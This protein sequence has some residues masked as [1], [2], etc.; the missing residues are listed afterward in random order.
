M[1][2]RPARPRLRHDPD[3]RC[4]RPA[5]AGDLQ[6]RTG[7][8][9]NGSGE[10]CTASTTTSTPPPHA[11]RLPGPLCR[12]RKWTGRPS[13]R[14]TAPAATPAAGCSSGWTSAEQF[15][16]TGGDRSRRPLAQQGRGQDLLGAAA[17]RASDLGA[18]GL[19]H[20]R[21]CRSA[22]HSRLAAPGCI[23]G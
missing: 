18:P 9:G 14:A 10:R 6:R 21:L 16:I 5:D 22:G 8:A 7:S 11:K 2:S 15:S 23:A 3:Q 19:M 12:S 13:R 1:I 17:V 4:H 20:R